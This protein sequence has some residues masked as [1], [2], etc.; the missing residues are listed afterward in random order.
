MPTFVSSLVAVHSI[1]FSIVVAQQNLGHLN[2]C[3]SLSNPRN[4]A[5]AVR[6]S[7]FRD[8]VVLPDFYNNRKPCNAVLHADSVR[9]GGVCT[10]LDFH[11]ASKQQ[12]DAC[13]QSHI[14]QPLNYKKCVWNK[15]TVSRGDFVATTRSW[16]GASVLVE[17]FDKP[18]CEVKINSGKITV[19]A[20]NNKSNDGGGGEGEGD[21]RTDG[22]AGAGANDKSDEVMTQQ[23][24]NAGSL[25]TCISFRKPQPSGKS[26]TM[27]VNRD[28]KVLPQLYAGS[29]RC[30]HLIRMASVR[31]AGLCTKADLHQDDRPLFE[32]CKRRF[33]GVDFKK[34]FWNSNNFL[35]S[36]RVQ[37]NRAKVGQYFF[38]EIFERLNCTLRIDR[39]FITVQ[40]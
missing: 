5:T 39:G 12:F 35:A 10:N 22:G 36:L 18:N 23:P 3:L 9:V 25:H 30:K 2:T 21:G 29:G 11:V 24:K 28:D 19:S 38:V 20:S 15:S 37:T 14:G 26:V 7:I 1:F 16:V 40:Q 32:S 6:L 8:Q 27:L 33:K 31:V 13:H 4:G 17:L 34:C